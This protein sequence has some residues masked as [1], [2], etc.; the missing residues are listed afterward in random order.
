ME[1]AIQVECLTKC[2]GGLTALDNLNLSVKK[3]T[4]FGLLGANG[5]G[6][7]TAIQCILG[8]EKRNAG[9]V[10][11]LGRDPYTER[12]T[13]FEEI[14]VQFQESSYQEKITVWELCEL[15]ASLYRKAADSKKLLQ[16]FGLTDKMNCTVQSLSGGQRQKLFIIL[17]LIP[18]PKIVFL[19]ELTTGLDTRARR[20]IWRILSDLKEDGLTVFLTSHFMEE[21][22]EL[23]DNIC[24]LKQGRTVF[25]GTV[26][27]AVRLSP[28]DKFEDAYLWF[29][30]GGEGK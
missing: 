17:A 21:V 22:E 9:R 14:G 29:T 10:K 7:S 3:G 4:V 18:E 8:V 26:A 16:A 28:Y 23:C 11:I 6:K 12:R 24:I 15:T 13:L 1:E 25:D 19:D 20:E 5:A 27:E 30:E 2:Y